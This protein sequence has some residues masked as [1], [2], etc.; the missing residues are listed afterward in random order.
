MKIDLTKLNTEV[1]FGE[2]AP[3]NCAK[4]VSNEIMGMTS[5]LELEEVCRAIHDTDGEVEMPEE[6]VAPFLEL[7]MI[8]DSILARVKRAIKEQ[9]DSTSNLTLKSTMIAPPKKKAK[10]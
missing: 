5:S 10:N 6:Q 3:I 2:F 1:R 9:L 8:S 7:V 4:F